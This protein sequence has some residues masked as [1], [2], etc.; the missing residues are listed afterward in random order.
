VRDRK[1][2]RRVPAPR[3]ARVIHSLVM[4][5]VLAAAGLGLVGCGGGDSGGS[6]QAGAVPSSSVPSPAPPPSPVATTARP[7]PS[8]TP[9]CL[10]KADGNWLADRLVGGVTASLDQDFTQAYGQVLCKPMT[11][12]ADYF[13]VT[14]GFFQNAPT[15]NPYGYRAFPIARK[16]VVVDG[17]RDVM[18]E[19]PSLVDHPVSGC[20]ARLLTL[21]TGK[22]VVPGD[23]KS[24]SWPKSS[25]EIGATEV[26][27]YPI[28]V[29]FKRT[30]IVAYNMDARSGFGE[31]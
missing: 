20:T 17:S 19:T 13:D 18:V 31:C 26:P 5:V 9:T 30:D 11:V 21:T 10:K 7:T 1:T 28:T 15:D 25:T 16:K 3:P 23:L 6:N 22:P 24:I 4:P 27:P 29:T 8:S 12:W 14:I 2:S